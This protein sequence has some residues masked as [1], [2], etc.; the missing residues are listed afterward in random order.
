MVKK[1]I[2]KSASDTIALGERVAR[3]LKPGDVVFLVG[4]LGSGK[5]TFAKGLCRGLGVRELVTSS[6]FVIVSEYKGRIRINHIDLYRLDERSSSLLPLNDYFIK[7]GITIIEWA[8]RI[9]DFARQNVS[10][11]YVIF[12]TKKRNEREIRIEDIRH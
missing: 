2:T 10:G 7:D 1:Y 6:S 3:R 11:F 5:T 4:E 8:D 12:T 9:S